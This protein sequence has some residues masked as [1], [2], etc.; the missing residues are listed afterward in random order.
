VTQKRKPLPNDKKF[1]LHRRK[2]VNEIIFIRQI[3]V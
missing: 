2:P 3:K 1:I